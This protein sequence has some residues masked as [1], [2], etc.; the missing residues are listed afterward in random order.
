MGLIYSRFSRFSHL[1]YPKRMLSKSYP[2]Q[3]HLEFKIQRVF[4]WCLLFPFHF[5]HP[6]PPFPLGKDDKSIIMH[7]YYPQLNS[8]FGNQTVVNK[9]YGLKRIL[10][11]FLYPCKAEKKESDAASLFVRHGY[12]NNLVWKFYQSGVFS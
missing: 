12:Q 7:M 1:S 3:H 11:W 9:M 4:S 6:V 10:L 5:S 2:V 8:V